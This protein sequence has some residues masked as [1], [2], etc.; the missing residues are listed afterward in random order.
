M[1]SSDEKNISGFDIEK[2]AAN[3]WQ[4]IGHIQSAAE[5]YRQS[6]WFMDN[7]PVTGSNYYRLNIVGVEGKVVYSDIIKL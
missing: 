7:P 1:E 3:T 6:L 5:R 2:M 4:K